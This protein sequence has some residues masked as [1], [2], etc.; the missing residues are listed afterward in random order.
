MNKAL[1]MQ[2]SIVPEWLDTMSPEESLAKGSRRDLERLNAWMGNAR[3]MVNGLRTTV[4]S[5]G[6]QRLVEVGAGDA[7]F[8]LR[9]ARRLPASWRGTH[10]L[11]VDRQATISSE[12]HKAFRE[13]GWHSESVQSDI[14]EWLAASTDPI[15]SAVVA[16]LFL[17]HFTDPELREL[18]TGIARRSKAFVAVEPRRSQ[19]SLFFSFLVGCIGCNRV[20]RHDAPISVRAGFVRQELSDLWP[21]PEGWALSERRAGLFGHMFMA[22]KKI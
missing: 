12:T 14:F 13:I 1:L 4:C 21:D 16:N 7:K 15:H 20:T 5:P 9:V 6:P 17:H 8:A 11:L 18:L 19:W 10:L 3:S 22:R 2:R